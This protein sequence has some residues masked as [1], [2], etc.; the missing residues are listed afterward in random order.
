MDTD[1]RA[2]RAE[3]NN[4]TICKPP[5]RIKSKEKI[6]PRVDHSLVVAAL[7]LSLGAGRSG[8]DEQIARTQL[9]KLGKAATALVEVKTGP[10]QGLRQGY[11]SAFCIHQSGLFVTNEHVV[12][13]SG[14]GMGLQPGARGE[15]TLVLNPGEKTEKSYAAR[16]VR[17][18]RQ[19]DLALLRIDSPT[20]FPALNL[21]DDGQL[22]ELMEVIAFGFP[23]GAGIGDAGTPPPRQ[24]AAAN[25]RDY[26]SVSVNAGSI[27]ALRRKDGDLDRIQLDATIN[28]GN[29][30][31]P[32]LDK[33]GKVVG[34]VVSLA[35][36]Q[37]LG[38]TGISHAIPVSHLKRFLAR[39][40][41]VFMAPVVNRSNQDQ[42]A[43]FRARATSLLPTAVPLELE[44]VLE[45]AGE[46]E[47]RY[48]M[49]LADGV[50]RARAVP[51]PVRKGPL[52]FRLD[53]KYEDGAV[54]GI[55]EDLD[56][57]LDRQLIKLSQVEHIRLGS[58]AKVKL[59]SG[60]TFEGSLS[61]LET[62]LVKVGNQ[63][64]RLAL[65]NAVEIKVDSPDAEAPVS[66][67]VVAR[68]SGKEVGR[69]D[70]P[71]YVEGSLQ[72]SMD[73]LRDGKFI[74]PPRSNS[75]V[76]YL[77]AIS[78]KGD[79]IGQGKTYSYPAEAVTVRRNDRG[80][81]ISIGGPTGWHI[82]FGAPN[83]RFLEVGEY[84]DARRY[85]FSGASPGIE[86]TGEGRGCNQIS[87]QFMVWELEFKGNEVTKL[88]IDFVQRCENK[89]PPLYGRIRYQSSFH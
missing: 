13:P 67:L 60:G 37:G 89:M 28:P 47:R 16:V 18:D 5:T 74:K 44:L 43:E 85:P 70:E 46:P 23:F 24:P 9:A 58:K 65:A 39:P 72:V 36:A 25:R 14:L 4:A 7:L 78:S 64:L 52:T 6:M 38:R 83:G 87:G 32:V 3:Q 27:T 71:L 56:F 31:G 22:E 34:L 15:I 20:K 80:V 77:R 79:Y 8:A 42:P 48:P 59:G 41:I 11:G 88:A 1:N 61:G 29:S 82:S 17:T 40:D 63:P 75:P 86:F 62:I 2:K 12:Y 84:L 73:A 50:Y 45:R 19:L 81:N 68:Q 69:L 54:A 26:P 55:V 51:F 49:K 66:C 33:S 10:L 76:S 30:G 35:V 57:K 21:G 53:V